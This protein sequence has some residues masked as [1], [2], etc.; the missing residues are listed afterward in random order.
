MKQIF[1]TW[2]TILWSPC[3]IW[4]F[5]L[6]D[7]TLLFIW[8]LV[9]RTFEVVSLNKSVESLSL[10]SLTSITRSLALRISP[11]SSWKSG[12]E[13]FE[14]ASDCDRSVGC[15]LGLGGLRSPESDDI[16]E[17]DTDVGDCGDSDLWGETF[18][19]VAVPDVGVDESVIGALYVHTTLWS[20]TWF[21]TLKKFKNTRK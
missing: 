19:D 9:R 6:F 1:F 3:R 2:M 16:T 7:C 21:S 18:S 13:M 20:S 10:G 15:R 11:L 12:E 4:S 8:L 5:L 14:M 17:D